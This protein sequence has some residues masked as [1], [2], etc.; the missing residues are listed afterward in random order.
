VSAHQPAE[1]VPVAVVTSRAE[2][3]LIVGMLR[4]YGLHAA[5]SPDDGGGQEPEL[6]IQ[7]VRLLAAPAEAAEAL[8]L[9]AAAQDAAPGPEEADT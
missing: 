7:G 9:I 3:E 5:V 8:R 4:N 2:A 1:W 6:Q